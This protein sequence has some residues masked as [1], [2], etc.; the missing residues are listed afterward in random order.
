MKT[1]ESNGQEKEDLKS[2]F[3]NSVNLKFQLTT[4]NTNDM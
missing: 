3:I 2:K 4:K 1:L